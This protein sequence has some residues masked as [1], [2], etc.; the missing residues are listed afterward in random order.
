MHKI[1]KYFYLDRK[2][3][4]RLD[5]GLHVVLKYVRD[6]S[7]ERIIKIIKG[8]STSLSRNIFETHNEALT[9]KYN[10]GTYERY[11]KVIK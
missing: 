2:T 1:I 8:K 4:K 6:K 5:K 7:V 10:V 11:W 9:L 3:V